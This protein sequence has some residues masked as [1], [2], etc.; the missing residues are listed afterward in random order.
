[1]GSAPRSRG[2]YEHGVPLRLRV[3]QATCA[4]QA[5]SVVLGNPLHERPRLTFTHR[6][7]RVIDPGTSS[8]GQRRL[9]RQGRGF[10]G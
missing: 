4:Q 5:R 8:E 2:I 7:V 1:M 9:E 6:H 3:P 10:C